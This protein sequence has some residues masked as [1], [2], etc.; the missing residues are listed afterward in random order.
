MSNPGEFLV[1]AEAHVTETCDNPDTPEVITDYEV[2]TAGRSDRGK[3]IDVVN[4]LEGTDRQP[5]KLYADGG[6]PTAQSALDIGDKGVDFHAPV[7]RGSMHV[8]VMSRE[9][10][11]FDAQGLVL[12][13]PAG[14][15]PTDHRHTNP[16]AEGH[17]LH[18]YFDGA[19]CRAC[20][21]QPWC[22]VRAPNN[23]RHGAFR[24][25]LRQALRR[26]DAMFE[27]QHAREWREQ[28]RIR[29]GV[30]A[31]MS[32]LKRRHGMGRLRVR[33]LPQVRFAVA[34]KVTA[35]NVKRWLRAMSGRGPSR[36]EAKDAPDASICLF[37]ALS[38]LWAR[39]NPGR[40]QSAPIALG[41]PTVHPW[42]LA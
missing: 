23:G 22:P 25:D 3:A 31:T 34:C 29:S 33:R 7:D 21:Q 35:C 32:E 17:A 28:Y 10:F 16:N 9:Q 6:Y 14:Y 37:F 13:C 2:H 40:P 19:R 39:L 38:R 12:R 26:R 24:L 42:A 18:A 27:A 15:A 36:N 5:Q 30:E 20:K 1:S 11:S 8:A 4:R 41:S